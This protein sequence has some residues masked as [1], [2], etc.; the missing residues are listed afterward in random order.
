MRKSKEMQCLVDILIIVNYD[1]F[2]MHLPDIAN[3]TEQT[4]SK[5][6]VNGKTLCI[7]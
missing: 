6:F 4:F 5:T 1:N 3:T 2:F 7:K